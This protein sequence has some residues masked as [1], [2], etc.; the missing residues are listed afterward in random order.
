M[1]T[2]IRAAVLLNTAGRGEPGSAL[3]PVGG[4]PLVVHATRKL[5]AAKHIIGVLV[6]VPDAGAL[7]PDDPR[8][9]AHAGAD[10]PEALLAHF[11]PEVVLVH[12]AVRAFAPPALIDRVVEA[13]AAGA[14]A[15]RPVLPCSDT[16]KQ[17]DDDGLVVGTPDRA[18]LWVGQTPLGFAAETFATACAAGRLAELLAGPALPVPGDPDARPITGPFDLAVAEAALAEQVAR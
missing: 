7:L 10:G 5:L 9:L 11:N 6:A 4:V 17:L 2:S 13:V 12:E 1:S 14:P 18:G 16:V 3:R 15:I 8:L